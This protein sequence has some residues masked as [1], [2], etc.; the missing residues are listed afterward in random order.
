MTA[1]L[2]WVDLTS[3]DRDKVR[4]ILD[5]FREQGTVDELGLGRLRDML[6]DAMFPGTSVLHTR[7]RYALF[8]P[9]IYRSIERT[10]LSSARLSKAV[11][12]RELALIQA[13]SEN[14]DTQG[15]IGI[16]ARHTLARMPSTVYWAALSRWGIFVP[17]GSQGWYHTNYG[18]LQSERH[19]TGTADDP[20]VV[21]SRSPTWHPRLPPV[22]DGFPEEAGFS[23]SREDAEFFQARWLERCPNTLLAHLA[24]HGSPAPAEN[25][26]DDPDVLSA[27][28]RV[29]EIVRLAARFSLHVEGAPLVYNLMLAERRLQHDKRKADEEWVAHYQEQIRQWAA[30]EAAEPRFDPDRMWQLAARS[31][32]NIPG[33]LRHFLERWSERVA[34]A[35]ATAVGADRPTRTLI[36]SREIQLKGPQRARFANHA[37]LLDWS[38]AVGVG[39]M[40]FR[41]PRVR[42]LLIDLHKGLES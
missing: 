10:R 34:T 42:Q 25:L 28:P 29:A 2:S 3:S 8:V 35:G 19:D 11:R 21:W 40:G 1:T 16:Q 22:P 32:T 13:L 4:R 23:L 26:W 39:R 7:L 14:P 6:S 17:G 15:I 38:G 27:R 20:G 30:E 41:W 33:P 37:R 18:R 12:D 24:E 31:G 36:E 5:L 9:W